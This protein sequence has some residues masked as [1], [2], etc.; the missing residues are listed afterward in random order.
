MNAYKF[1]SQ[2]LCEP[3]AETIKKT[4]DLGGLQDDG[5]CNTYPQGPVGDGGGIDSLP[6]ACWRCSKF[7]ENP[8]SNEGV[9]FVME[10]FATSASKGQ[11][12]DQLQKEWS[13]F[14]GIAKEGHTCPVPKSP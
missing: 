11:E 8:L 13:S 5:N 10:S 9:V 6:R 7:L 3:C 4:L 12:L 1:Y 14:Y 2:R